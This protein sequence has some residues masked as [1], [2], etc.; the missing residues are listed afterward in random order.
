MAKRLTSYSTSNLVSI[1]VPPGETTHYSPDGTSPTAYIA[2]E[3]GTHYPVAV[4]TRCSTDTLVSHDPDNAHIEPS[5]ETA[6]VATASWYSY[7]RVC[8]AVYYHAAGNTNWHPFVAHGAHCGKIANPDVCSTSD[9]S[10]VSKSRSP[11]VPRVATDHCTYTVDPTSTSAD[12]WASWS[13]HYK[14]NVEES[15]GFSRAHFKSPGNTP[16]RET[17][18]CVVVSVHLTSSSSSDARETANASEV[19]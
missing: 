8:V 15:A 16:K 1:D 6:A 7:H 3:V 2:K 9:E 5:G 11:I 4:G 18:E 19:S 17:D 10:S 13:N 14:R 12:H